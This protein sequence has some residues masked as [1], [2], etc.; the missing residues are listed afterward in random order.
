MSKK[1]LLSARNES[2]LLGS[3]NNFDDVRIK[4]IREEFNKL[5]D[6]FSKPL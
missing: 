1:R 3:E 5:R 4:K 6:R 2:E